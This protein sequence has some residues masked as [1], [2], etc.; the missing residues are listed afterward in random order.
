[1]KG[2]VDKVPELSNDKYESI[3]SSHNFPDWL[4]NDISK[5]TNDYLYKQVSLSSVLLKQPEYR[6]QLEQKILLDTLTYA[7]NKFQV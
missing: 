5:Y 3:Y 1:M 2:T 7:T 4:L 6:S